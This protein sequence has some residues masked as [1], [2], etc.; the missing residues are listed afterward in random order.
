[1]ALLLMGPLPPFRFAALF[2]AATIRA[3]LVLFAIF[4]FP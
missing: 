2:F 3:P 1:M 4:V